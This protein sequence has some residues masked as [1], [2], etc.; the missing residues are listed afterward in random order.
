[1]LSPNRGTESMWFSTDPIDSR[2]A[3]TTPTASAVKILGL[4][5][6]AAAKPTT[7]PGFD[8]VR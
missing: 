6:S 4:C 1:M 3:R 8:E 7:P 2:W 5:N